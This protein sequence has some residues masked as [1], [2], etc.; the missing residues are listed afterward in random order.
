VDISTE[1][2][3]VVNVI[4]GLSVCSADVVEYQVFATHIERMEFLVSSNSW[5]FVS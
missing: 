1:F 4:Q 3:Y 2:G 5:Q